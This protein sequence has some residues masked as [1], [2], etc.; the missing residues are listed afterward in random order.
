[1]L[2]SKEKDN[3]LDF[4]DTFAKVDFEKVTCLRKFAKWADEHCYEG[5]S[6]ITYVL[7]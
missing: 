1:M 4:A 7:N 3:E 5:K 6:V 2:E